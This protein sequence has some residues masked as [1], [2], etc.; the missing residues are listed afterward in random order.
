MFLESNGYKNVINGVLSILILENTILQIHITFAH[1]EL[2]PL[3]LK[4]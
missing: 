3:D 2:E 1:C 4:C